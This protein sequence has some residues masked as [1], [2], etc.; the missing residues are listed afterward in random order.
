MGGVCVSG[1]CW[2]GIGGFSV[3]VLVLFFS[4]FM[5]LCLMCFFVFDFSGDYVNELIEE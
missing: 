3:F 5:V 2:E 1:G 4:L